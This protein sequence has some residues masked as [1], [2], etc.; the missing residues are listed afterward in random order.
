MPTRRGLIDRIAALGLLVTVAWSGA[1][2]Q[3]SQ[4]DPLPSWN[5]G[6][7]KTAITTY[8]TRATRPGSDFVPPAERI[9]VFDN[10]AALWAEQPICFQFAFAM[11]QVAGMGPAPSRSTPE[12]TRY[13]QGFT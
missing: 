6:A 8:V 1:Q 2:A 3:P 13:G 7:A 12:N 5:A 9:A 11:D 10:D 4:T